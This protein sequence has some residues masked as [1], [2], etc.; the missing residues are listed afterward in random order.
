[1]PFVPKRTNRYAVVS[2]KLAA[3]SHVSIKLWHGA[4]PQTTNRY[5]VVSAKLATKSHV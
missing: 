3:N 1:M 5:A 2:T 4:H